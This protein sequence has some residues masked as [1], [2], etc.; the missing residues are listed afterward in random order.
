M[1]ALEYN[2]ESTLFINIHYLYYQ[3]P[4]T[5]T[6]II[7]TYIGYNE[8]IWFSFRY[9]SDLL[10]KSVERTNIMYGE[11]NIRQDRIIFVHGSVDPWH[12]LGVTENN[13]RCF[14]LY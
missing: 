10:K 12:A 9:D 3:L 8:Y 6:Y 14:N 13:K 1:G 4:I 7:S 2:R 5:I 11:L